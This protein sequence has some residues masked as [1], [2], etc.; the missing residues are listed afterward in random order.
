M[1]L[2]AKILVLV[3][4]SFSAVIGSPGI[5]KGCLITPRTNKCGV[6]APRWY[7]DAKT[8]TCRPVMWGGC[9]YKG[10]VF[11]THSVCEGKCGR[12]YQ[13]NADHCLMAPRKQ[14]CSKKNASIL[15]WRF[16]MRTMSC[17]ATYYDGCSGSKNLH[18]TCN[19]CYKECLL[20]TLR[21]P[22]CPDNRPQRQPSPQ[23][24]QPG[25]V[26]H[27]RPNL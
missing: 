20:H 17:V 9:G 1:G 18:R 15:M 7:Y 16:E 11:L 22:F 10:N 5:P 12:S 2:D 21:L 3:V 13:P 4:S 26:L 14:N 6:P 8:R 25:G 19:I 23:R 24:H 27:K